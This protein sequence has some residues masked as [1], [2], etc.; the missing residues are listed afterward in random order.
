MGKTKNFSHESFERKE[1]LVVGSD[2]KFG[3]LFSAVFFLIGISSFIITFYLRLF[4]FALSISFLAAAL[5][6]P[7]VLHPFNKLWMRF[8]LILNKI[9][10][11]IILAV[12]FYAVFIPVG[13]ILKIF[14]KDIL[15]L[16]LDKSL[17]SYWIDST[18]TLSTS[19]KDQF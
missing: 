5:L 10:S 2:K 15:N 12:L 8:G 18:Q 19:M 17:K 7:S 11:P 13:L 14:R 1:E 4:L 3:Y 9:I 6:N 16:R